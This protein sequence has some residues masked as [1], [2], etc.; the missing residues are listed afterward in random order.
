[1]PAWTP[2]EQA[3][4]QESIEAALRKMSTLEERFEQFLKLD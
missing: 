1:V 2:A 3:D 4:G